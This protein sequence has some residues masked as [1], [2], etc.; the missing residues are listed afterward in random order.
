MHGLIIAGA[1]VGGT[2]GTFIGEAIGAHQR[3]N[4]DHEKANIEQKVEDWQK[5]DQ[6]K[7][8]LNVNQDRKEVK[9]L[10][11]VIILIT[12]L[13]LQSVDWKTKQEVVTIL[14]L[15]PS[16]PSTSLT[17]VLHTCLLAML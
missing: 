13:F 8:Q 17:I 4:I 10:S 3:A 16:F 6:R 11:K 14:K 7:K 5:K 1:T 2:L 9:V 12:N 15:P